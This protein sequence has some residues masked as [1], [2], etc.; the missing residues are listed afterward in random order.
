MMTVKRWL[1]VFLAAVLLGAGLYQAG[2]EH[3]TDLQAAVQSGDLVRIHIL[4]HDD[5][6]EQQSI[7][8]HVRDAILERFTPLLGKAATGAEAAEIVKEHMEDALRTAEAA[9]AEM[10][11]DKDVRVE[12]GVYDFPERVYG[13]QVVPAGEYQALR[14]LLGD[15]KG[16]NW[17]CVMYPP[18]CFSGEDYE[19][20]V[21]FESSLVKWFKK[22]KREIEH[23]E[24]EEEVEPAAGDAVP[25]GADGADGG[26]GGERLLGQPG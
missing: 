23:A 4:A 15:A 13:E 25:D 18:L 1:V 12:F 3:P 26:G 2:R 9:A 6:D 5:T 21:K 20:E 8:L 17:W 7:K 19:G 11:F 16:H 14:I 24:D 10:G 22:W